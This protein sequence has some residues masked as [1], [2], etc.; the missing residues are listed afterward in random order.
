TAHGP[1]PRRLHVDLSQ[2]LDEPLPILGRVY[3]RN[4]CAEYAYTVASQHAGLLQLEA[5]VEGGL[6]AETEQDTVDV[7]GGDHPF[8]EVSGQ[9]QEI[10]V[11]RELVGRLN[12]GDVRVDEDGIDAFLFERLQCLRPRVVELAGLSD[13]E[14]ARSQHEH[15]LHPRAFLSK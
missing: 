5:A 6:A 13:P 2:R 10:D 11:V 7:L 15:A 3:R 14:R 12:R 4:R 8:D 9:R 1:A